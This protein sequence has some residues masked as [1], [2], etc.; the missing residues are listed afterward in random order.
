MSSQEVRPPYAPDLLI[1]AA[2]LR[3]SERS[4]AEIISAARTGRPGLTDPR[5][6]RFPGVERIEQTIR[7]PS[8]GDIEL[9]VLR[10]RAAS[11]RHAVLLIHGGGFVSGDRFGR[12]PL[13]ADVVRRHGVVGV[14]L[15]Y[16]LAPEHPAP[17]ALDDC[18]DG[19]DW[20]TEHAPRLG[21]DASRVTLMG[22]S[23]GGGLAASVALRVRDRGST[24]PHSLVLMS[25]MLDHRHMT[26]SARQFRDAAGWNGARNAAAWRAYLAGREPQDI[27]R[28]V[29]PASASSLSG[30]PPVYV[31]VGSADLFRD[32]VTAFAQQIWSDGGIADL[33][34]WAGG[35][36]GSELDA[37]DAATSR[38]A[39]S[40][41]DTWL[42]EMIRST[43]PGRDSE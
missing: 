31:D 11:V 16:R 23:A 36:H 8:N 26:R 34:V 4:A 14:S 28:H 1:H 15:D 30:L 25:P 40:A 10:P 37:P 21:F 12:L 2:R 43:S 29:V 22:A 41:R 18:T 33:H 13:L 42:A 32:E 9:T 27:G 20:L 5:R 17:A 39:F 24:P 3:G 7:R 6:A 19:F 35:Y 38:Q